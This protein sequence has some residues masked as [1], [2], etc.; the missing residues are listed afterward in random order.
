M[1]LWAGAG[2]CAYA[3]GRRPRPRLRGQRSRWSPWA[4]GTDTLIEAGEIAARTSWATA[5]GSGSCL[6][7]SFGP[8]TRPV[9][10]EESRA[11]GRC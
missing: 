1:R 3:S 11:L 5:A 4:T 8:G 2:Q 9:E 7:I 10:W 6:L